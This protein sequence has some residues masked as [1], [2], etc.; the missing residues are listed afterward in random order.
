MRSAARRRRFQI[1][2]PAAA[3]TFAWPLW[4]PRASGSDLALACARAGFKAALKPQE[5]FCVVG[6]SEQTDHLIGLNCVRLC[7]SLLPPLA[8]PPPPP[9]I[10]SM[11]ALECCLNRRRSFADC[12]TLF[13]QLASV[14][15]RRARGWRRPSG[16]PN[17]IVARALARCLT[18]DSFGDDLLLLARACSAAACQ[19]A[20]RKST[21][22]SSWTEQL[23]ST[24]L[25]CSTS[26]LPPDFCHFL[27]L[28]WATNA[29]GPQI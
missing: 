16:R 2:C 26:A 19:L 9:P 29:R 22:G 15:T 4:A 8:P 10:E 18:R 21:F 5:C 11:M 12:W 20:A 1:Q 24:Q 27:R 23:D 13:V 17:P 14:K 28:C 7:S 6:P 25:N 3:D